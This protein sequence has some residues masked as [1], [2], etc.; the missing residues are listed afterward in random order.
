MFHSF[1]T[2]FSEADWLFY[3]LFIL[4]VGM[5]VAEIF[6]PSFGLTGLAGILLAVGAVT[7]RCSTGNNTANEIL[8]YIIYSVV[9]MVVLTLVIKVIVVSIK[10]RKKVKYTIVDGNKIPLTKEGNLDYSFLVGEEGEVISDLKPTGKVRF[11]AGIFEVTSTKEYIYSG[12]WVRVDKILNGK[13][14]VRK[15]G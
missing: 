13:I 1:I 11:E 12:S 15:K 7:E 8:L 2:L 6:I 9:L 14:V 5:F 10:N 4:A 3:L